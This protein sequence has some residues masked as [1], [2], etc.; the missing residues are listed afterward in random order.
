MSQKNLSHHRPI[1]TNLDAL[2]GICLSLVLAT[3]F[4]GTSRLPIDSPDLNNI[5]RNFWILGSFGVTGFFV[6]SAYLLTSN[7]LNDATFN[8]KCVKQYYARRALRIL[9]LYYLI[10]SVAICYTAISGKLAFSHIHHYLIFT[11]N[12]EAYKWADVGILGHL[13]SIC[14]EVQFY[15]LLPLL[16]MV[17]KI[18]EFFL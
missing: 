9:P 7:F 12:Q 2:R 15:I 6:L 8:T 18:L 1:N 13:W 5:W 17:K 14:V 4:F 10:F 16:I 11:A 3:H